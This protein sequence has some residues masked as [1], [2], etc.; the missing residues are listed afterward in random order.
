VNRNRSHQ[1]GFTLIELMIVVS[2]IG[3]LAAVAISAYGDY[4]VKSKLAE[5]S[6]LVNPVRQAVSH[7][8]DRWGQFPKNNASAGLPPA[9]ALRGRYVAEIE[10]RDGVIG[11][12]LDNVRP[13]AIDGKRIFFRPTVN[14][15][16]PT[17]AI[18]WVVNEVQPSAGYKTS[19]NVW[20]DYSIAPQYLPKSFGDY[21]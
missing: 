20:G 5:A 15:A 11:L 19:G 18:L 3:I 10:V 7:Y 8:Y 9:N 21:R 6:E 14:Q 4:V 1:L 17:S 16:N 13:D 2:I 12:L